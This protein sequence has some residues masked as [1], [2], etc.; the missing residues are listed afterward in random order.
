MMAP[1]PPGCFYGKIR[2]I[3]LSSV[4]EAG[5][6]QWKTEKPWALHAA[7]HHNLRLLLGQDSYTVM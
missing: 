7:R 2:V 6:E 1:T 3:R 5:R 4:L